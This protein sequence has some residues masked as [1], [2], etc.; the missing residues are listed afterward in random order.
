L[1]VFLTELLNDRCL[2]GWRRCPSI[3]FLRSA[4]CLYYSTG[5]SPVLFV[6]VFRRGDFGNRGFVS[7]RSG[8]FGF[9]YALIS[10]QLR[11]GHTTSHTSSLLL[12]FPFLLPQLF[13][14]LN[15]DRL[16]D[17]G[18]SHLP[19]PSTPDAFDLLFKLNAIAVG[20]AVGEETLS[21]DLN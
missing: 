4:I 3:Y 15:K 16:F 2:R 7:S 18:S 8:R 9:L 19:A 12:F 6:V 13:S 21:K 11:H 5:C 14:N 1:D 20:H 10:Y 17:F